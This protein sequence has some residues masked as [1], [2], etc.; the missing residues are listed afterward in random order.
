[1]LDEH[2]EHLLSQSFDASFSGTGFG[3]PMP[4]SQMEGGL[5]FSDDVFGLHDGTDLGDIGDELARELGEGWG[6]PV[7]P[8]GGDDLFATGQLDAG[9]GMDFEFEGAQSFGAGPNT[10]STPSVRPQAR[11]NG[12]GIQPDGSIIV[13]LMPFSPIQGEDVEMQPNPDDPLQAEAPTKPQKKAKRVRLLLDARTEL[14]DEELKAA[15]ANYMEGQETIRQELVHKKFEK[16]SGK[17]MEELIWGVPSGMQAPVLVDFWMQNFK[18]QVEARAA[19]M[20][21]T[22]PP[23]KRR[24]IAHEEFQ[25]GNALDEGFGAPPDADFG[26]NADMGFMMDNNEPAGFGWWRLQLKDAFFGVPGEESM[27]NESQL[28]DMNTLTL[29]RNSHNFLESVAYVETKENELLTVVCDRYAKMQLKTFPSATSTL[30]FDD[31]VPKQTSTPH[32]AAAAFYHC[33]VLA[34]KNLV[35]V[36]QEAPY[37]T[38]SITVK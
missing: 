36:A 37:G 30:T 27:A 6:A 31:V 11:E 24:R 34:T 5:A 8:L 12:E 1:M 28:S 3:A 15:R 17:I 23:H 19:S 4:A 38:L 10:D 25:D 35:G 22:Q 32:V 7:D 21:D 13:P 2:H 14:T 18:L 26:V 20:Q 16:E 33:L 9:L 29:E